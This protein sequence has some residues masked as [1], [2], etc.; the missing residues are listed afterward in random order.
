MTWKKD[1][2]A[3]ML[4]LNKNS[5]LD[6]IYNEVSKIRN[7]TSK[8]WKAQVRATLERNSS[9]SDAWE[10]KDDLFKMIDKGSGIWGLNEKVKK[11]EE[12]SS[13]GIKNYW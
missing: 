6:E 3:A 5:H 11:Q 4:N 7:I 13:L 12:A 8:E 10:G 1:V 9:D 2:L